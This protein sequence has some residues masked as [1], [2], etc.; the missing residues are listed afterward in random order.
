[1][2][3]STGVAS[4][5]P[6]P[7]PATGHVVLLRAGS[8]AEL[9]LLCVHAAGGDVSLYRELAG[10]LRPGP[11]ILGLCPPPGRGDGGGDREGD[12]GGDRGDGD[13][14]G[15]GVERLAREHLAAIRAIQ[16][17][18]PY[19]LLGECSG[20]ALAHEIARRLEGSGERVSLLALFDGF[21][22]WEP[23][24]ARAMPRHVYRG[25][26]R[27]RIFANHLVNLVRLG[28]GT[29]GAYARS[30]AQRARAALAARLGRPRPSSAS[31][32][33]GLRAAFAGNHPVP[34]AGHAVLF[35]AARLPW[36]LRAGP[37]LGWASLLGGL[38]IETIDGYFTTAISEPGVHALAERLSRYL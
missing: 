21:P 23:P 16:P 36:G 24:L 20:G 31:D 1:M 22:V 13:G 37:D 5:V 12:G 26:H 29:R 15:G 30:K 14:D 2:S 35:R 11:A 3:A 17:H 38:E 19:R 18:G 33:A 25:L 28:P 7:A 4:G 8:S 34:F 32:R 6:A 27:G 10:H 9:P